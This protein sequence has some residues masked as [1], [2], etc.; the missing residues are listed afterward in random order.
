MLGPMREPIIVMAVAMGAMVLIV[1][2]LL[3]MVAKLYRRV[4]QSEALVVTMQRG[5]RVMRNG[6][7]VFPFVSTAEVVDLSAKNVPC[8]CR[9]RDAVSLRDGT[10]V[11][12]EATFTL[13]VGDTNE[14]ILEAAKKVGAARIQDEKALAELFGGRF[15]RA[16][17]D[18]V[19][20]TVLADF[21]RDRDRVEAE[22]A[23]VA[24][25]DLSGMVIDRVVIARAEP[26]AADPAGP[27]R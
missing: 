26:T 14:D 9:A 20:A 7:L 12:I 13:R 16:I 25:E 21:D 10:R 11:D 8:I 5:P 22:V 4:G 18:V 23:K 1:L 27:F 19:R 17:A 2:G 15:A 24:G 3:V 6:G